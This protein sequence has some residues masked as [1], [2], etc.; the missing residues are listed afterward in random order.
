MERS[1]ALKRLLEACQARIK[2]YQGR[3]VQ[4]DIPSVENALYC[5]CREL[6]ELEAILLAKRP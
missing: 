1:E 3:S 4:A 6:T 5:L 2:E